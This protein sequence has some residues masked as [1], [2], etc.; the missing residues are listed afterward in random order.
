MNKFTQAHNDHLDPDLSRTSSG[1]LIDTYVDVRCRDIRKLRDGVFRLV[2][3]A[4]EI[5]PG[6]AEILDELFPHTKS[7]I[8]AALRAEA[9][10][11]ASLPSDK[12]SPPGDNEA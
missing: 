8:E 1:R 9:L 5:D 10:I 4:R 2:I 11:A 6:A 12:V 3:P 7:H